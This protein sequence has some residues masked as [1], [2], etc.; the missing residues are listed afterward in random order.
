MIGAYAQNLGI[1]PG[2]LGKIFLVRRH[3]ERSNGSE[4][5]RVERK[6]NV[7]APTETR[8]FHFAVQM[9]L[10]REIRSFLTDLRCIHIFR[11]KWFSWSIWKLTERCMEEQLETQAS[12]HCSNLTRAPESYLRR[13]TLLLRFT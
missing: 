7:L 11:H 6:N 3:L 5:H 1:I 4:G 12:H 9:R 8:K 13:G 2:E 10:Q